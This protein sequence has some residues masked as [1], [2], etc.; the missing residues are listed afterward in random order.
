M[1]TKPPAATLSR[2]NFSLSARD[3]PRRSASTA[4]LGEGWGEVSKLNGKF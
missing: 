1:Q 2:E 4:G 3:L